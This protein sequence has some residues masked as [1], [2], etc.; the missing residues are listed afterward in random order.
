MLTVRKRNNRDIS[1][2]GVQYKKKQTYFPEMYTC[3]LFTTTLSLYWV[4][5][6]FIFP[7]NEIFYSS[8][9]GNISYR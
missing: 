4:D 1:W 9:L 6:L 3:P 7:F 2:K 5:F 8:T